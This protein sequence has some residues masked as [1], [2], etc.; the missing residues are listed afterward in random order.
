MSRPFNI[1]VYGILINTKNQVLLSDEKRFGQQFTKFPGGGL[2][3]GEGTKDCLKREFEEELDL[4]VEVDELIY[5]TDYFQVSAF[6]K[7]E[8]LISIYYR[9]HTKSWEDISCKERVYDF[10][11]N[12]QEVQRWKSISELSKNDLTFPVDKIVVQKLKEILS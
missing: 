9:V 10:E 7:N 6:D 8:Q 11:G 1:R 4:K 5:L 12:E 2:E 3:F